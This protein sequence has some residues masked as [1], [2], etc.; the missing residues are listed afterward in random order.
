LGNLRSGNRT[1]RSRDVEELQRIHAKE[2][3]E[4]L[5]HWTLAPYLQNWSDVLYFNERIDQSAV[6]NLEQISESDLFAIYAVGSQTYLLVQRHQGT[7]W[8]ALRISGDGLF[9]IS[10]LLN[11]AMR[12]L[13]RNVSSRLSPNHA[14][15]EDQRRG[16]LPCSDRR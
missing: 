11:D 2:S 4:A 9:R 16:G 15:E 6:E 10:A 7:P 3:E 1:L 5:V 14:G 12:H 13:Y 8:M